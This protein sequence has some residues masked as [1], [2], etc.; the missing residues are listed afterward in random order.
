MAYQGTNSLLTCNI[1]PPSKKAVFEKKKAK[2]LDE[3]TE[4][5]PTVIPGAVY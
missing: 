4:T 3:W 1:D 2:P 5:D